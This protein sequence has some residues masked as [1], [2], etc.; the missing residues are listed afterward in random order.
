MP[1]WI[2]GRAD[3]IRRKAEED[4][5]ERNRRNDAA[6]DLK[7]KT[8]PFWNDLMSDLKEAV[9]RFNEEFPEKERLIDQVEHKEA[10]ILLIRRTAY[11][12]VYIKTSLNTSGTTVQYTITQ[13]RR[14]GTDAVETQGTFSFGV[15]DGEVGYVG[16]GL[17]T[18]E[19]VAKIFLEPFFEF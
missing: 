2:K 10:T 3:E 6:A 19:D 8:Q 9:R 16:N 18:H 13:T 14:R 7:A 17:K 12:A 11:P 1:D 15:V 5:V 4:R